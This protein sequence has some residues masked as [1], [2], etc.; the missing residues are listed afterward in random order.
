MGFCICLQLTTLRARE[1]AELSHRLEAAEAA[2][3]AHNQEASAKLCQAAADLQQAQEE[4]QQQQ[5][6]MDQRH[7]HELGMAKEQ[8]AVAWEKLQEAR[9]ALL[10]ADKQ[11]R[12]LEDQV[13][14][15][16]QQMAAAVSAGEEKGNREGQLVEQL[17]ATRQQLALRSVAVPWYGSFRP[18]VHFATSA[19][20]NSMYVKSCYKHCQHNPHQC[21]L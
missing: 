9:T 16:Q 3:A 2:G 14:Q 13:Q 20:L 10:A 19:M 6:A 12:G 7:H 11:T 17:R 4:H 8:L 21:I 18:K 1:I 5:A 15:L